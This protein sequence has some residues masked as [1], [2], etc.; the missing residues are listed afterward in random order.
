MRLDRPRRACRPLARRA[1]GHARK[2]QISVIV[3]IAMEGTHLALK[4]G[5]SPGVSSLSTAKPIIA[6]S[7]I[8]FTL[9]ARHWVGER[10]FAWMNRNRRLAKAVEATIASAEAFL[11]AA[12]AIRRNVCAAQASVI[13][14]I[15]N[16]MR[17]VLLGKQLRA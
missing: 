5:T 1:S 9:H 2:T 10:F 11:Y 12:S 3:D 14:D 13:N 7:Q 6:S 4:V 8:D 17:I 16:D 15:F